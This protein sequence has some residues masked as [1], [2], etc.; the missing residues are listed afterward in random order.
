MCWQQSRDTYNKGKLAVLYNISKE[1]SLKVGLRRVAQ[2]LL[3]R[4]Q[5]LDVHALRERGCQLLVLDAGGH[6][7]R[8][9]RLPVDRRGHLYTPRMSSLHSTLRK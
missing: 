4:R 7:T 9:T 6:H 2:V 8:G 1:W 3:A 5:L